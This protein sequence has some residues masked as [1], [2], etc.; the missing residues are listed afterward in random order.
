MKNWK[1]IFACIAACTLI[2]VGCSKDDDDGDKTVPVT[3]VTITEGATYSLAVDG[4][5]TFRATVA[6]DNATD[7]TV[8]WSSS[9]ATTLS[10]DAQTGAARG[11][12]AGTATVTATAGGR[13]ATCTVTVA[14]NVVA[15]TGITLPADPVQLQL[16]G[17]ATTHQLVP[18]IAPENATNTTVNYVSSYP[19]VATVNAEGLI[20]AV[21]GGETVILSLIHI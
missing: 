13:T 11:L 19:D 20:T 18:T 1:L 10:I 6:P 15:V 3:S 5:H 16:G 12:A 4:T 9:P 2:F 17:E 8:S 21:A 14:P 7:K